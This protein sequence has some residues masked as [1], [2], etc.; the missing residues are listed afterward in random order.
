MLRC[1][2]NVKILTVL[3][4]VFL[5]GC[6][7][8]SNKEIIN[9]DDALRMFGGAKN[10]LWVGHDGEKILLEKYE[11]NYDR[12]YMARSL[13][14]PSDSLLVRFYKW[15]DSDLVPGEDVYIVEGITK[16][17]GKDVYYFQLLTFDTTK[18]V[19]TNW[20]YN[21]PDNNEKLVENL[22]GLKETF[23]TM[24][25]EKSFLRKELLVFR[26]ATEFTALEGSNGQDSKS[27]TSTKGGQ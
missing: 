24:M 19:W 23:K 16:E 26:A 17:K 14:D 22:D 9:N 6:V 7:I 25:K 13:E 5:C 4:L 3:S 18:S 12:T 21:P 1:M 11:D 27:S 2:E 8:K 20:S 15:K 10:L